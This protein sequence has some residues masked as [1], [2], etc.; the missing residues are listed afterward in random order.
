MV[1]GNIT[2]I[3]VGK[4]ATSVFS[5][6]ISPFSHSEHSPFTKYLYSELQHVVSYSLSVNRRARS[7]LCGLTEL[8]VSAWLCAEAHGFGKR[9][10]RK[11][12]AELVSTT[13]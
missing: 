8:K 9:I 7:L 12:Y 6:A 5:A 3:I 13:D 4:Y 2:E 1:N 11:I 10:D